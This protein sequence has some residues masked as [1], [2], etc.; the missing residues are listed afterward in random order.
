MKVVLSSEGRPSGEP[1]PSDDKIINSK[2]HYTTECISMI[3]K[4][5][6]LNLEF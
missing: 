4:K 3:A 5:I 6:I 2:S 1:P